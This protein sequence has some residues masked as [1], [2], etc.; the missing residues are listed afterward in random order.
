M[1]IKMQPF[2]TPWFPEMANSDRWMKSIFSEL[3]DGDAAGNSPSILPVDLADTGDQFLLLA[4]L[5]GTKR[6]D[7]KISLHEGVLTISGE[8]KGRAKPEDSR[9]V[10]NEIG[11]GKF[12]RSIELPAPVDGAKIT[13]TLNDGILRVTLPKAE[14]ARPRE[15]TIQ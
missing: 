15:I 12:Q 3:I 5:P 6:E 1:I 2:A 13:A 9:W 14:E 10:R 7:L 11:A 8:R 4:E